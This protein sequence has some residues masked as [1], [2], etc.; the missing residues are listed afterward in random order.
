MKLT[1][2]DGH[3]LVTSLV[4]VWI[5]IYSKELIE[6]GYTVTSLVEVWIEIAHSASFV[7]QWSRHFPCGSVD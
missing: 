3:H 5:E 2:F 6:I 7:S 1:S 4:E